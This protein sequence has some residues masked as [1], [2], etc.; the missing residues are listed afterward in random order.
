MFDS[1][2]FAKKYSILFTYSKSTRSTAT[3]PAVSY[4]PGQTSWDTT[5]FSTGAN[6]SS[7][8]E[9]YMHPPPPPPVQC[10]PY[11][12]NSVSKSTLS[13]GGGGGGGRRSFPSKSKKRFISISSVPRTFG[14]DC[15][16]VRERLYRVLIILQTLSI[17]QAFLFIF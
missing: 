11:S 17:F 16:S 8:K 9:M 2:V 5:Y 7:K 6:S 14:Q 13:G 15:N 12:K 4:D 1:G 3:L 10:C